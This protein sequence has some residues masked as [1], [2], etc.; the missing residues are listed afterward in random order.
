MGQNVKMLA[1][2][3]AQVAIRRF[4]FEDGEILAI[5]I[6]SR[7]N[8]VLLARRSSRDLLDATSPRC[9]ASRWS[10]AMSNMSVTFASGPNC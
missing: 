6:P 9:W 10:I 2:A 7:H 4:P 1:A 8:H 3:T 5:L